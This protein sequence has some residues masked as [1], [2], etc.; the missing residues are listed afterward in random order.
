MIRFVPSPAG[1]RLHVTRTAH[2]VHVFLG[3]WWLRIPWRRHP[4]LRRTMPA[5]PSRRIPRVSYHRFD[6]PAR[7]VFTSWFS[8]E[9]Y[10]Y[11]NQWTFTVRHHQVTL[12]F[13]A[14]WL[15]DMRNDHRR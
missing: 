9:R 15:A 1:G 6:G 13:R 3:Q 14:D 11:G 4:L 12:D 8:F 5:P 7:R 2:H 10:W